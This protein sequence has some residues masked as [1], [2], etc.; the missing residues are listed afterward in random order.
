MKKIVARAGQ[1]I[2]VT[3]NIG[4]G[5]SFILKILARNG[6]ETFQ[7]DDYAKSLVQLNKGVK[8]KVKAYFPSVFQYDTIDNKKLA[9]KIF[10]DNKS[11][12]II[13][14]IIHPHTLNKILQLKEKAKKTK[15]S[16]VLESAL[17]FE[18]SRQYHFD[19]IINVYAPYEIKYKRLHKQRCMLEE[20]FQ[21]ISNLQLPTNKTFEESDFIVYNQSRL[22]TIRVMN[23]LIHDVS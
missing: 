14:K 16:I 1:Y 2:G 15:R 21:K 17:I 11:L 12:S 20:T 19:Y 10:S 6:F 3:G 7:L 13:E 9:D 18:K 23:K 5:K 22:H 4:S 8:N